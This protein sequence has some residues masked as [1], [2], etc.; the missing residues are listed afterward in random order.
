MKGYRQL[1]TTCEAFS[2]NWLVDAVVFIFPG[3]GFSSM[4]LS[5]LISRV[6]KHA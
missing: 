2:N 6:V 1:F 4:K 5:E 3:D